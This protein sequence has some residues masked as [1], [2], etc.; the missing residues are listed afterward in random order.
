MVLSLTDDES[1]GS[2]KIW[3]EF[4]F[5][6]DQRVELTISKANFLE[7]CLMYINHGSLSVAKGGEK[8]IYLDFVILGQ[9]MPIANPDPMFDIDNYVCKDNE[10]IIYC[11]VY[12][13]STGVYGGLT[14]KLGYITLRGD[15]GERFFSYGYNKE[16]SPLFFFINENRIAEHFQLYGFQKTYF[17]FNRSIFKIKRSFLKCFCT[18]H[19]NLIEK[20]LFYN[21]RNTFIYIQL[22]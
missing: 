2:E 12:N 22:I 4:G 17:F 19:Q 11:P 6:K 21:G 7:N 5:F 18:F 13:K 8:A 10:V 3:K 16:K 14:K 9:I 20:K 1:K 15:S